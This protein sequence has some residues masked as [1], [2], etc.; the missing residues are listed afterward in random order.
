MIKIIQLILI[1]AFVFGCQSNQKEEK[2]KSDPTENGVSGQKSIHQEDLEK[3]GANLENDFDLDYQ[4][5]FEE[6]KDIT[7]KDLG[8][9][10]HPK[11]TNDGKNL[12]FTNENY[13]EIWLYD[14]E[15][16]LVEKIVSLPNCGNNFQ[17][18]GDGKS[19]FFRNKA[20]NGKRGGI[21]SI[22]K[23]SIL[24]GNIDVVYKTENRISTP[25][26]KKRALYFL[27]KGIS[28]KINISDNK[29]SEFNNDSFFYV[30]NNLLI[31]DT[32]KKDTISFNK[33]NYKFI[34]CIASKTGDHIFALTANNGVQV[35]TGNGKI[36]NSYP[37]AISIS[38]A[39]NSNLVVFTEESDDGQKIIGSDLYIGFLNSSK[40][41]KMDNSV[42]ELRFNPDWSPVDNRIVY[43]TKNGLVKI[44]LF[45][46][47]KTS[48]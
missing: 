32:G 43:I 41:I 39:L 25:I 19:I 33:K 12:V 45:N 4:I 35:I 47:E 26:L 21:Y 23:Y 36:I 1:F 3:Y 38:N 11:F 15:N 28:K 44:I 20:K 29:F 42:N 8:F 9:F 46:I 34:N 27:E 18:S 40:K 37:D 14:F 13:S 7:N 24:D 22:L 6:I 5:V 2:L 17:L 16:E 31:K 30:E 10:Q 48:A